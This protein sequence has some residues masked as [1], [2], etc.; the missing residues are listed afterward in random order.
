MEIAAQ[1][2]WP[3]DTTVV[4]EPRVTESPNPIQSLPRDGDVVVTRKSTPAVIYT[5]RQVPGVVQFHVSDRDEALQ[6]ARGFAQRSAVDLWFSEDGTCRLLEAH[7]GH[8]T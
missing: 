3:M 2:G 5:V 4:R 8:E 1:A 6:L 7:R